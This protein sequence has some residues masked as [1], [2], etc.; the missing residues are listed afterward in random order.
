M[1]FLPPDS[2]NPTGL[3]V[4]A[5]DL[6]AGSACLFALKRRLDVRTGLA[7]P[8]AR[9]D[10]E[11][12]DLLRDRGLAH[13]YRVLEGFAAD[14]E[15]A[16]VTTT[17]GAFSREQLEQGHNDTMAAL[18]S[19]ADVVYQGSFFDGSFHGKADFL[20]RED[21]GAWS[22]NDTKLASK[23]KP[24]YLIQLA[25]Y[26]DQLLA[27]GV[28]VHPYARVILRDGT[29]AEAEL[30]K[31]LPK[32]RA[33]R[34][35]ITGA[36]AEHLATGAPAAWDPKGDGACRLSTCPECQ[37]AA[38]A[39]D[40]LLLVAG[41]PGAKK[42][43]TLLRSQGITTV[44][45][46]AT[47]ALDEPDAKLAG[48]QDQARLQAGTGGFDG[49]TGGV[50][51]RVVDRTALEELPAPDP[52]DIFFDFEGDPNRLEPSD[53]TW[54]L[55]YLFGLLARPLANPDAAP[56]FHPLTAHD[57]EQERKAFT[58]FIELVA[59]RRK[60]RPEMHIYHYAHYEKNALTQL[61]ARHGIF[62]DEVEELNAEVLV[63]LRPVVSRSIRISEKSLSIKKLEPLYRPAVREG[64][65]N[66]VD[67]ITAYSAYA[68]AAAAGDTAAAEEVLGSILA[69]N[70]DDCES[71]LQLRDWLLSL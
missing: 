54:G 15:V 34:D 20:V 70:L 14:R 3:V 69:Y 37:E 40:D 57:R 60:A 68:D 25:A 35:R 55:E 21:S 66:A 6:A 22:V 32:F 28:P 33:V 71:T 4:S 2:D 23:I 44:T 11:M 50:R 27:A 30:E 16:A 1:F 31:V 62:A 58:D 61:A 63:D 18:S 53:G 10:Q 12:L 67:S 8:P 38:A 13:E 17:E 52:G 42:Y 59:A 46:L 47:A 45:G 48:L 29:P 7:L 9:K 49:E 51:Y 39:A 36:L 65:A 64:V 41:M 5:S 43:R 56:V 19:G 24:E 26:A